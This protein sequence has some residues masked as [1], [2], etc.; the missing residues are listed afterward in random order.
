MRTNMVHG[1]PHAAGDAAQQGARSRQQGAPAQRWRVYDFVDSHAG[2]G[3]SPPDRAQVGGSLTT[4]DDGSGSSD[5]GSG[6]GDEDEGHGNSGH[7]SKGAAGHNRHRHAPHPHTPYTTH[8]TND[9]DDSDDDGMLP[10]IHPHHT[11]TTTATQRRHARRCP[12]ASSHSPPLPT[13]R[14][15][16]TTAKT[17]SGDYAKGGDTMGPTHANAGPSAGPSGGGLMQGGDDAGGAQQGVPTP[18]SGGA[19]SAKQRR[20]LRELESLQP[21]AY[22]KYVCGGGGKL[23][24]GRVCVGRETTCVVA[25]VSYVVYNCTP[26]PPTHTKTPGV[27]PLHHQTLTSLLPRRV[28][29]GGPV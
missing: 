12:M 1:L 27:K 5:D 14:T 11:S 13:A 7:R 21:F 25:S 22:D 16:N 23:W 26:T 28:P 15:A 19:L 3:R 2:G 24:G 8:T 4:N 17:P 9:D 6:S 20:M 18:H 10:K 29:H